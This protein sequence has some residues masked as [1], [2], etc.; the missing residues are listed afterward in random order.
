[1]KKTVGLIVALLIFFPVFTFAQEDERALSGNIHGVFGQKKLDSDW[2]PTDEHTEFGILVDFQPRGWPLSIAFEGLRSEDEQWVT[3]NGQSVKLTHETTEFAFGVKKYFDTKS[4][5][6]PF[7]GGGLVLIDLDGKA[8]IGNISVSDSDSG[9][10]FWLGGGAIYVFRNFS[11]GAY[12]RY[13]AAEV[14]FSSSDVEAGG[15][16]ALGMA[17]VHF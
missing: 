11:I 1:M 13:S 2:E 14:S 10:G 5:F 6:Y 16:H 9:F 8:A 3:I 7:V 15:V 17:G 12:L 4:G